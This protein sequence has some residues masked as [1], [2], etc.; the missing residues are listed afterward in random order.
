MSSYDWSRF[1]ARIDVKAEVSDVYDAWTTRV[2]LERWFLRVAEFT[3]PDGGLRDATAAI[4]GGDHYRWLWH[5]YDDA[6]RANYHLGCL[7]G[8]T[9][10]L[11][12]LK[13]I[14]EGGGRPSQ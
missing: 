13:S 6:S 5:G 10:Y 3:K 2:G 8:W 9:F 14:L 12:N 1:R 11:A 7:T 4:R